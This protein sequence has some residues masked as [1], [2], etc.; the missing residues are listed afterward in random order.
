MHSID[1]RDAYKRQA[2]IQALATNQLYA[3]QN[4]VNA[5]SVPGTQV[6]C[7]HVQASAKSAV[8]SVTA[9]MNAVTKEKGQEAPDCR[10]GVALAVI[11]ACIWWCA[12]LIDKA[13]PCPCVFSAWSNPES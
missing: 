4:H 13:R 11:Q 3:T 10:Q 12:V 5:R 9:S 8:A 6:E 2:S 1:Q 7:A